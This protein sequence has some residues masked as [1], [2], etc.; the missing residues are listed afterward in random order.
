MNLYW[1]C[2]N[3]LILILFVKCVFLLLLGFV[4]CIV[5]VYNF[6]VCVFFLISIGRKCL[7]I[8]MVVNFG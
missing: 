1:V 5:F 4:L 2:Y 6:D 3:R 7:M 8:V